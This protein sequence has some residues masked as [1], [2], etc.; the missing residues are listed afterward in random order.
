M[1]NEHW[2]QHKVTFAQYAEKEMKNI[3]NLRKR[4]W[5]ISVLGHL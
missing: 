1:T 5:N 3:D 2:L 4:Q